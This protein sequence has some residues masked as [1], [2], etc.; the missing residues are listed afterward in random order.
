MANHAK[1]HI[2]IAGHKASEVASLRVLLSA[3]DAEILTAHSSREALDLLINHDIA[4]IVIDLETT[5]EEGL[6]L[7]D[8]A[9]R[10]GR[11]PNLALLFVMTLETYRVW[12]FPGCRCRFFD[13]MTTPVDS[14]LLCNKVNLL[15]SLDDAHRALEKLRQKLQITEDYI[16]SVL[17][18]GNARHPS[19]GILSQDGGPIHPPSNEK[20]PERSLKILLVDDVPDNRLVVTSYLEGTPH[21]VKEAANGLDAL[22]LFAAESFDLILMDI[23]MPEMDGLETTR[24]IRAIE[25][26]R[27]I[28]HT[29][30]VALTANA[31]LDDMEKSL[32]AGC[33]MHLAKPLRRSSLFDIL[34][35]FLLA[36]QDGIQSNQAHEA[37]PLLRA[38]DNRRV[39]V[40]L[41]NYS[42][43]ER[44]KVETG[45]GFVRIVEMFIKNLPGRIDALAKAI[46]DNNEQALEQAAHKLKGTS[47]TFGALRF[48]GLCHELESSSPDKRQELF[49]KIV[50]EGHRIET[51]MQDFLRH[52]RSPQPPLGGKRI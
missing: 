37:P 3:V 43:L 32:A 12:Q 1:T 7:A 50:S 10:A 35:R 25:A 34:V 51:E 27:G 33:D 4:L 15:L 14:E 17:E 24:R 36:R 48:S 39:Q 18:Y 28:P 16:H 8:R 19:P 13:V 22:A 29:M 30:V 2:L 26:A 11:N 52:N 38:P 41:I 44:M 6:I 40:E 45:A 9:C 46:Q 49:N 5:E 21:T 31:M 23:M 42:V 47:A 20:Q